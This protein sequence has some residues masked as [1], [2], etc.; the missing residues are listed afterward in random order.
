[1]M[2]VLSRTV[3]AI[4][5]F[6]DWIWGFRR[7]PCKWDHITTVY[8]IWQHES[9]TNQ[10]TQLHLLFRLGERFTFTMRVVFFLFSAINFFRNCTG[11]IW[12]RMCRHLLSKC[13]Q[14]DRMVRALNDIERRVE[15][16]DN[17]AFTYVIIHHHHWC[18]CGLHC[19]IVEWIRRN[20]PMICMPWRLHSTSKPIPVLLNL[21]LQFWR[22]YSKTHISFAPSN[23]NNRN[24]RSLYILSVIVCIRRWCFTNKR[25]PNY[26]QTLVCCVMAA[27]SWIQLNQNDRNAYYPVR[28]CVWLDLRSGMRDAQGGRLIN[29]IL[30]PATQ[31]LRLHLSL[32][33][34]TMHP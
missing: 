3:Q 31:I 11:C 28:L 19:I 17:Y 5:I 24:A 1:M 13:P 26:V 6:E 23:N 7:C 15:S 33:L 8:S 29:Y 4:T 14:R 25:I 2:L 32:T 16:I 21:H 9:K 30:R 20:W 27:Q 18:V 10:C 34:C 22:I 12:C